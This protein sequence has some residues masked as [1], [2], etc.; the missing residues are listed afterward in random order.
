MQ[1]SEARALYDE[2]KR[3]YPNSIGTFSMNEQKIALWRWSIK[4]DSMR[5]KSVEIDTTPPQSAT[6]LMQRRK[7]NHFCDLPEFTKR[8]YLCA[9]DF[10]AGVQLYASGS[11]VNGD[12]IDADS[13][14][15]VL[16]M[17]RALGKSEKQI[18]DFDFTFK[19]HRNQLSQAEQCKK[20]IQQQ[21]QVN[22]DVCPFAMVEHKIP[23]PMWDFDKLTEEQK[24]QARALFLEKRWGALMKLHNHWKLSPNQYCCNETPIIRW[25]TWAYENGK[26]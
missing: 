12:Y 2:Y 18:S 16:D 1:E 20:F 10:F 5:V 11:R 21:F 19:D 25:F 8:V 26:I 6:E 22:T 7:V 13:P 23:V 14:I 17:R 4:H 9:A 15:A 24:R 3:L